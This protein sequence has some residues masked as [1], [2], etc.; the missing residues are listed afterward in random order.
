MCYWIDILYE[1]KCIIL[2]FRVQTVWSSSADQN[3]QIKIKES[4]LSS[5]LCHLKRNA[6]S[7]NKRLY[8]LIDHT[9]VTIGAQCGV[10]IF[11]WQC[12]SWHDIVPDLFNMQIPLGTGISMRCRVHY[13]VAILSGFLSIHCFC[14]FGDTCLSRLPVYGLYVQ[15]CQVACVE[16]HWLCPE[17]YTGF[18]ELNCGFFWGFAVGMY[19]GTLYGQGW[20]EVVEAHSWFLVTWRGLWRIPHRRSRTPWLVGVSIHGNTD[21]LVYCLERGVH[22]L[23]PPV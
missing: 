12:S 2:L 10:L 5:C 6:Q 9:L 11:C 4:L 1:M 7:T 16:M 23:T 13:W 19:W 8:C 17:E 22:L 14:L 18:V 21:L 20:E 3:C 15:D